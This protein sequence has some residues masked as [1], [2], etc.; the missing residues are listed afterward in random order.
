MSVCYEKR[1]SDLADRFNS[2][3]LLGGRWYASEKT[4]IRFIDMPFVRSYENVRYER[5]FGS[6]MM[7]IQAE[8]AVTKAIILD[9]S[10]VG[11]DTSEE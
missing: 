7:Q 11:L 8:S 4:Y 10:Y 3:K 6:L 2:W 1:K 5:R 9:Y